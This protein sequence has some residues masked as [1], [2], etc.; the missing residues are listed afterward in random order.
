MSGTKL[1][2]SPEERHQQIGKGNKSAHLALL[3]RQLNVLRDPL[4]V[5]LARHGRIADDLCFRLPDMRQLQRDKQTAR[6][7][8]IVLY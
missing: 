5:R 1:L 2:F 6:V 8:S 3:P 4:R 7:P